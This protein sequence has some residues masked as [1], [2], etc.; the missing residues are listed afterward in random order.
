MQ[1]DVDKIMMFR[2][3][4]LMKSDSVIQAISAKIRLRIDFVGLRPAIR[5]T[6]TS[7]QPGCIFFEAEKA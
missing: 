1:Q 5:I 4:N 2:G 3:F 7:S 6:L